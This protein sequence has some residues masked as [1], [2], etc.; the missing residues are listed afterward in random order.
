MRQA[1]RTDFCVDREELMEVFRQESNLDFSSLS[2]ADLQRKLTWWIKKRIDKE[3]RKTHQVCY[4][5]TNVIQPKE[6][7]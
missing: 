2:D 1:K 5:L 6:N 4:P 7:S 3:Y